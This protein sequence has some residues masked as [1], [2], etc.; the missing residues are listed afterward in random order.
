[1]LGLFGQSDKE[2]KMILVD[3][4]YKNNILLRGKSFK[5]PYCKTILWYSLSAL[6]DDMRC[7]CCGN[8][9]VI[10]IFLGTATLDDSFRLNE[11]VCNAVDQGILPLLLTASFL[12]RQR[13]CGKRFLFNKDIY[14]EKTNEKLGEVDLI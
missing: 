13:F 11:L 2:K 7:Y 10:P 6:N 1:L 5:C 12:F 4:L 9:V 8:S 14:D 3:N